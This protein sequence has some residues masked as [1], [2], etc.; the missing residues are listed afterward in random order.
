M[1]VASRSC[2]QLSHCPGP[3]LF[4]SLKLLHSK[5]HGAGG[6]ASKSVIVA[7]S[8]VLR[9]KAA[10]PIP[11]SQPRTSLGASLWES[12]A[13]QSDTPWYELVEGEK[14]GDLG[15]ELVGSRVKVVGKVSQGHL[16]GFSGREQPFWGGPEGTILGEALEGGHLMQHM[17]GAPEGGQ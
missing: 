2:L 6:S 11:E 8:C 9:A 4:S 5:G 7:P 12:Q 16:E 15:W 3:F 10:L 1:Q 14:E 17:G 13:G